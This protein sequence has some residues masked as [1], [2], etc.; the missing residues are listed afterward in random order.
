MRGGLPTRCYWNP[1]SLSS[2][3]RKCPPSSTTLGVQRSGGGLGGGRRR[4]ICGR[5]RPAM[6]YA[7]KAADWAAKGDKRLKRVSLLGGTK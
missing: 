2:L 5:R 3:S 6:D 7:A 1:S 4:V